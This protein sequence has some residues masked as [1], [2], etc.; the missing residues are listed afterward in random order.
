MHSEKIEN[1]VKLTQE[2]TNDAKRVNLAHMIEKSIGE[3]K[4]PCGVET[5]NH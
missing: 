5:R 3:D 4:K 1:L 2:T